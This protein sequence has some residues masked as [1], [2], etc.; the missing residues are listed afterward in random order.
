VLNTNLR[1]DTTKEVVEEGFEILKA[2]SDERG[3]PII[4][5]VSTKEGK[6]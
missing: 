3:I 5:C 6:I 1:W 2:V 4:F